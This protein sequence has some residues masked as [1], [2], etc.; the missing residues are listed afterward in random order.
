MADVVAIITDLEAIVAL[1]DGARVFEAGAQSIEPGKGVAVIFEPA[2]NYAETVTFDGAEDVRLNVK[3]LTVRASERVAVGRLHE[4]LDRLR[5][6]LTTGS[7]A[8]WDFTDPDPP[9]NF[10]EYLFGS[11]ENATSYL[12]FTMPLLV[13]V[14]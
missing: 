9:T 13:A 3:V 11:G 14:S 5:V 1:L 10:G 7:T 8:T 2:P 6:A 4:F 12:G